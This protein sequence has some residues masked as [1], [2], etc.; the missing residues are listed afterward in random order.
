MGPFFLSGF[1]ILVDSE[2]VN[3]KHQLLNF[4]TIWNGSLLFMGSICCLYCILDT[5]N[6]CKQA[7]QFIDK[8]F[9]AKKSPR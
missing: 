6:A 1:Q 7:A 4:G 9:K 2:P 3:A 8:N 5:G